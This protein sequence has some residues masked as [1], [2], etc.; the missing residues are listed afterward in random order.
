M[1]LG[2]L[3]HHWTAKTHVYT[4][5]SSVN[6]L[7]YFMTVQVTSTGR[8]KVPTGLFGFS[9]HQVLGSLALVYINVHLHDFQSNH[10]LMVLR[11]RLGS[12]RTSS[13][14]HRKTYVGKCVPD[15]LCKW[16]SDRITMYLGGGSRKFLALPSWSTTLKCKSGSLDAE[17]ISIRNSAGEIKR[18]QRHN[19]HER[20]GRA[21]CFLFGWN[22]FRI[23]HTAVMFPYQL[24]IIS[25]I[26]WY[27]FLGLDYS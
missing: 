17:R 13:C 3:D 27:S 15:H 9:A 19:K 26:L 2:W 22:G 5:L 25:G 4:C 14:L 23:K 8:S 7:S 21:R 18:P 16:F 11:P 20:K 12:T 1:G 24:H 6:K 10:W